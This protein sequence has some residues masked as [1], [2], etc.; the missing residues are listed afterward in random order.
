MGEGG[1]LDD[2]E[3]KKKMMKGMRFRYIPTYLTSMLVGSHTLPQ[4]RYMYLLDS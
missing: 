1:R 2:D 4:L 3:K